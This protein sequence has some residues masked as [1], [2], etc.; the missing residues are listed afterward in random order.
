[1]PRPAPAAARAVTI[2]DYLVERA[3]QALTLSEISRGT[4]LS[5]SST[6]TVLGELVEGGYVIRHLARKTYVL[7]PALSVLGHAVKLR[8]PALGAASEAI[9]RI[10]RLTGRE[11]LVIALA[12]RDVVAVDR[13][14]RRLP[15]GLE[16]GHRVPFAAPLGG[17]FVAWGTQHEIDQWL[18]AG[19]ANRT[20]SR[21]LFLDMLAST[22]LRGYSVTMETTP[23]VHSIID[24]IAAAATRP[25]PSA[26]V[27]LQ[28]LISRLEFDS[29]VTVTIEAPNHYAVR[30]IAA[31]IF[32]F[33]GRVLLTIS[34]ADLPQEMD[35]Q[36][37]TE[38]GST[39]RDAALAVTRETD[40][41][42]PPDLA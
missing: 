29:S 10:A 25:K 28:R 40:G 21:D 6:Q 27:D 19:E 24:A 37:I 12:G 26:R 39:L 7:G 38:L 33:E 5:L 3:S 30:S 17:I 32:D 23:R 8:Y 15:R 42:L 31:P 13:W 14:G 9:R 4:G 35:V 34:T 20:P 16:I 41:R 11:I 36:E 1:M 18:E 2:I 22:R